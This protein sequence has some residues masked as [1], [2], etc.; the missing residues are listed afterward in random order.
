[1]NIFVGNFFSL[2]FFTVTVEVSFVFLSHSSEFRI[3]ELLLKSSWVTKKVME[4][5]RGRQEWSWA[6]GNKMRVKES[7]EYIK[8]RSI[9]PNEIN[10]NSRERKRRHKKGAIFCVGFSFFRV[11]ESLRKF[12]LIL[13]TTDDVSV[14]NSI[15]EQERH[16]RAQMLT[17]IPLEDFTNE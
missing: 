9:S 14:A 6:G 16:W 12:T 1:M 5:N 10:W 8:L 13:L 17:L 7:L 11:L 3:Q 15:S 4:R 2:L